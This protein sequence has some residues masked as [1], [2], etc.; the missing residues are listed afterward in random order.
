MLIEKNSTEN[1]TYTEVRKLIDDERISE[2]A[3]IIGGD[4]ITK[5]TLLSACELIDFANTP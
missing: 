3:R 2:V 4:V 5:T 1:N